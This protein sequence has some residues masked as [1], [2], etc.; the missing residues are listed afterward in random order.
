[1]RKKQI[2]YYVVMFLLGNILGTVVSHADEIQPTEREQ[3]LFDLINTRREQVHLP[4]MILCPDILQG[5]RDWAEKLHSEK[6]LYHWHGGKENCGCGY[7]N[8]KAMFNGWRASQGH[9]G[10][11]RISI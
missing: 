4:P 3:E 8:P 5:C 7:G 6:R 11:L 10:L 1:M 9:R 2:F